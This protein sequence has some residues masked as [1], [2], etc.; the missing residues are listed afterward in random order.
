MT[1][2][3]EDCR[4]TVNIT[5]LEGK[6]TIHP[7]A[8]STYMRNYRKPV[9]QTIG[10]GALAGMRA[11]AAPAL[12]SRYYHDGVSPILPYPVFRFV[13]SPVNSIATKLIVLAEERRPV[14]KTTRP[15]LNQL[16]VHVMSGAVAGATIFRK[17]RQNVLHGM[18]L[19][20]AAALLTSVAGFYLKNYAARFPEVTSPLTDAF[21][22]AF[23]MSSGVSLAKV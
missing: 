3:V 23:Q 19:G 22:D 1:C 15:D 20:G 9:W 21:Q 16:A 8:C 11:S 17:S 2:K 10:L 4:T 14:L 12:A 13:Q 5:Y 18:L 6:K 7:Y